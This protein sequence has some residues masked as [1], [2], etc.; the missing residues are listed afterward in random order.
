MEKYHHSAVIA[1]I[2]THA[3]RAS[4]V[5]PL[6]KRADLTA[7]SFRSCAHFMQHSPTTSVDLIVIE[8]YTLT[9]AEIQFLKNFKDGHR[10]RAPII[11]I[12]GN[13]EESLAATALRAGADDFMRKPLRQ[14]ELIAR[15]E[16]S[17]RQYL[18]PRLTRTVFGEFEFL[19]EQRQ[20][21]YQGQ[22]VELRPREFDLLLC[23]F[24][25]EGRVVSRDILLTHVWQTVP[26]L[27]TR[28][29]DT[30]VSRLR[31]RFG[32]NGQSGWVLM[33]VYQRGYCLMEALSSLDGQVSKAAEDQ[34]EYDVTIKRIPPPR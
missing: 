33:S 4:I 14:G 7:L 22:L 34:P 21:I 16:R 19:I 30:Y 1:V 3:H 24:Q 10:H 6:L 9:Q 2:S 17:L 11:V 29:I 26:N 13:N 23:L 5:L 31:K 32:L 12:A 8:G 28:S 25:H 20:L 27:P 15:I 18:Y